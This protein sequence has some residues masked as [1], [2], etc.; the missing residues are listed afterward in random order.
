MGE[1]GLASKEWNKVLSFGLSGEEVVPKI[2][3]PGK[4]RGKEEK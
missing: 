1:H 3:A 4:G 2:I